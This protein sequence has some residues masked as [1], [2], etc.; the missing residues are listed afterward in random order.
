MIYYVNHNVC[1][2]LEDAEEVQDLYRAAGAVVDIL[3]ETEYF[4]TL[5]DGYLADCNVTISIV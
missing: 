2:T 4:L 1:N 5:K 3:T